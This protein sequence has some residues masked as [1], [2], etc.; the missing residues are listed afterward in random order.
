MCQGSND[1][2]VQKPNWVTRGGKIFGIA[3]KNHKGTALNRLEVERVTDFI[4]Y[5]EGDLEMTEDGKTNFSAWEI[6]G[7][8]IMIRV[9]GKKPRELEALKIMSY[10]KE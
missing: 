4:A 5:K 10:S 3:H 7:K 2:N 6:W 1:Q 9:P 8:E